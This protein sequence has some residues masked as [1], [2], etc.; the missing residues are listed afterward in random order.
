VGSFLLVFIASKKILTSERC[1]KMF[2][3]DCADMC[4]RVKR[5]HGVRTP[6]MLCGVWA[7]WS[8]PFFLAVWIMGS[9]ILGCVV[10]AL[11]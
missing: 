8:V 6:S 11:D 1:E 5:A 2:E 10:G 3:G 9:V 4:T 7:V